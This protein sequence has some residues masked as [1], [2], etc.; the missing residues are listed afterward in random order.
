ME[1]E[2]PFTYPIL[3][4]LGTSVLVEKNHSGK[5]QALPYRA[6]E[7]ILGM[8]WSSSADIWN[9]GVLVSSTVAEKVAWY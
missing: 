3:C 9:F 2:E 8:E 4:D 1:Y 6:P 5:I 7:V